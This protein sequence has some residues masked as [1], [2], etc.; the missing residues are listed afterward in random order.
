[1]C[2]LLIFQFPVSQVSQLFIKV[3]LDFVYFMVMEFVKLWFFLQLF[4]FLKEQAFLLNHFRV[5]TLKIIVFCWFESSHFGDWFFAFFFSSFLLLKFFFK[6]IFIDHVT[7]FV[8]SD[9]FSVFTILDL[10]TK[11]VKLNFVSN[12]IVLL[13]KSFRQLY[14]FPASFIK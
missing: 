5:L 3:L 14:D 13:I 1:V 10:K 11:Q 6:K 7:N 8:V 9:H 2:Y 4:F 12:L